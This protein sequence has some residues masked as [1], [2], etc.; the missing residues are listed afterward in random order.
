MKDWVVAF[1]AAA[2]LF[3]LVLWTA[4]VVVHILR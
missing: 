2:C 1:L 4:Y 3:G